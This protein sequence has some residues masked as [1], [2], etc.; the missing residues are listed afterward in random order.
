ML[1]TGDQMNIFSF[2]KAKPQVSKVA[3]LSR[4]DQF[5]ESSRSMKCPDESKQFGYQLGYNMALDFYKAH[6]MIPEPDVRLIRLDHWSKYIEFGKVEGY[7]Q[8]IKD[9]IQQEKKHLSI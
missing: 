2:F 9:L 1:T 5:D 3:G 8:A 7:N 4:I 6:G